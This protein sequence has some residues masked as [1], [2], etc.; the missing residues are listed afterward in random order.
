MVDGKPVQGGG[1]RRAGEPAFEDLTARAR[2]RNVALAHFA[3]RGVN[4]TTIRGVAQD[5]GVSPSLVQ[6]H[7]GTKEGLRAAC[8]DYVSESLRS[9]VK[10]GITEH[11]VGD[12]GFLAAAYET[13]PLIVRYLARALTDGSA[14]GA[15][16]FDEV[17]A[18]TEEHLAN[19]PQPA[20]PSQR[21]DTRDQAAVFTAMKLGVVV[22]YRH[23][24][25]ALGVDTLAPAGLTRVSA[26]VLDV[27]SPTL[28]GQELAD[29]ARAGIDRYRQERDH[30]RP[31]QHD[32]ALPRNQPIMHGEGDDD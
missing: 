6:H 20:H 12:P 22:L 21:S 2:I 18:L 27:V 23:L 3:E 25:R 32:D 9:E 8:D 19:Q 7:F 4:G 13:A 17:V 10:H 30:D 14:A 24:S 26:A 1:P 28:T 16:L 5:A 31:E 29:V 11:G 15:A